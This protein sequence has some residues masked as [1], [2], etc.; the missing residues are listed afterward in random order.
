PPDQIDDSFAFGTRQFMTQLR[1]GDAKLHPQLVKRAERLYEAEIAYTD[2]QIG[3]LFD[4]LRAKDVFNDSV[5]VFTADHGEE[6]LEHDG[7]E[8]GHTLYPELTHVPLVMRYPS[9][10]TA[11][12]VPQS[13]GH[14]D[15]APTLCE[16]ID[17]AAPKQFVGRSLLPIVSGEDQADRAVLAHGNMWGAPLTSLRTA[18]H[19]LILPGT[20]TGESPVP[21]LYAWRKDPQCMQ[22]LALENADIVDDMMA[23]LEARES[24]L[25]AFGHGSAVKL[26]PEQAEGLRS[27]GYGEA[28][29]P[30]ENE[31]AD[32]KK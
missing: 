21:E 10:L 13:V 28:P 31:K 30:P 29:P 7:F 24:S 2:G 12:R 8:H 20:V 18:E 6:F 9:Q 14:I 5:I 19:L 26:T 1:Y 3:R 15:V 25:E 4:G 27:L 17:A 23:D 22:D 11:G 32:D 16:L